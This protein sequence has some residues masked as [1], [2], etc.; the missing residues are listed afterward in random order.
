MYSFSLNSILKIAYDKNK[1]KR[2]KRASKSTIAPEFGNDERIISR[3]Y[4]QS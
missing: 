4:I 2:A 3:N 1:S